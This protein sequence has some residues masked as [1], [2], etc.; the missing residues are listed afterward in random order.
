MTRVTAFLRSDAARW[1]SRV[2][3]AAVFILFGLSK[4]PN[5][6]TFAQSIAN[7][8]ILPLP[9]VN[10]VAITLPWIEVL[11]GLALLSNDWE[12]GGIVT[13][14]GMM[15]VFIIALGSAV[16]R[17]LDIDCGCFTLGEDSQARNSVVRE[18]LLDLI[19]LALVVHLV[20]ARLN[21][22]RCAEGMERQ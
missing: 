9:A 16:A 22:A 3:L 6:D 5:L 1:V 17:G 2:I 19:W 10:L 14:G 7:Y 18:L 11:A 4:I 12:A 13:V 20:W 8:R 21:E 15:L